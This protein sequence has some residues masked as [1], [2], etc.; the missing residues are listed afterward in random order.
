MF[1]LSSFVFLYRFGLAEERFIVHRFF[2]FYGGTYSNF[3]LDDY[4]F[5]Q[6]K[7]LT[8]GYAVTGSFLYLVKGYYSRVKSNRHLKIFWGMSV[9]L[10]FLVDSYLIAV[11]LCH[12]IVIFRLQ[13]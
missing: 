8:M 7:E 12:P 11:T 2:D 9:C 1:F 6:A 3:V 13:F 5:I 10:A 4:S